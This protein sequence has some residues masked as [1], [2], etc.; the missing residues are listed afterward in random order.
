MNDSLPAPDSLEA[1]QFEWL[2]AEHDAP[3]SGES[4][5]VNLPEPSTTDIPALQRD[6]ERLRAAALCAAR[7]LED[8]SPTACPTDYAVI[9]QV[10]LLLRGA[11]AG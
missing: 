10:A 4:L 6:L 5:P 3:D 8:S 2:E 9:V 1:L 7:R 11:V